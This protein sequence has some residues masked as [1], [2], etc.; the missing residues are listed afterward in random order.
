MLLLVPVVDKIA[1]TVRSS[2]PDGPRKLRLAASS[3]VADVASPGSVP[4][5]TYWIPKYSAV[6]IATAAISAT[7]TLRFGWMISSPGIDAISNPPNAN[8]SRSAAWLRP[9]ARGNSHTGPRC[10]SSANKPAATNK[11]SGASLE[12]VS[13]LLAQAPYRTPQRLIAVSAP[14]NA[15]ITSAR[16]APPAAGAHSTAKYPA[17][18]LLTAAI[19]SVLAS[20]IISPTSNPASSPN[21]A[22]AYK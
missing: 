13:A 9:A 7:P 19:A 5:A 10:G 16:P 3:G 6:T 4:C 1:P 2:A 8:T 21:A 18:A 17:N 14:I 12:T 11:S 20:T 15:V 22:R